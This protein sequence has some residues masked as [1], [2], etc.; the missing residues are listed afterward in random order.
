MLSRIRTNEN[1]MDKPVTNDTIRE[2]PVGERL[3]IRLASLTPAERKLAR[4]LLATYPTAGLESGARFAGRA[5][6]SAPTVTRFVGKLG[7]G[8]YPEFQRLLRDEV[9]GR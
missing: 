8:G 3:R 7:L 5:G 4:V 6:V 2:T 9:Q 1:R